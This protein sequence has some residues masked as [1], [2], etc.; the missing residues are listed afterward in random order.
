MLFYTMTLDKKQKKARIY[1]FNFNLTFIV[2][3]KCVLN[4]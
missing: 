2:K 1:L 3:K 4:N